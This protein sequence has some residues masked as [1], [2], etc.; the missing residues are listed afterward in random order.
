M[1]VKSVENLWN[2]S[3]EWDLE[4]ED[5]EGSKSPL[6]VLSEAY[7]ATKARDV[8]REVFVRESEGVGA[9]DNLEHDIRDVLRMGK[10]LNAQTSG[11]SLGEVIKRLDAF[12]KGNLD[13]SLFL[14]LSDL[15][16]EDA[17]FEVEVRSQTPQQESLSLLRV[18]FLLRRLSLPSASAEERVS[19]LRALNGGLFEEGEEMEDAR[20]RLVDRV[21]EVGLKRRRIEA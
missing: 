2:Q 18:L 12:S 9:D 19:L 3:S 4:E 20:D 13:T 11:S 1:G 14:S 7:T 15:I 5:G 8:L 10:S 16:S 6:R 21:R 17:S